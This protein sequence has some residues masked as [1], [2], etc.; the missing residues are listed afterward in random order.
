MASLIKT[1]LLGRELNFSGKKIRD[2]PMLSFDTGV[3][4]L[5]CLTAHVT[6]KALKFQLHLV[7]QWGSL[8]EQ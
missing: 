8:R 4:N 3:K 6:C 5:E 1:K 2:T 7:N